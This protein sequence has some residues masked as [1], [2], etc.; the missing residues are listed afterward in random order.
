M[1]SLQK[2]RIFF[3]LFIFHTFFVQAQILTASEDIHILFSIAEH[4][5]EYIGQI[6]S[7]HRT[8]V[9][10][11]FYKDGSVYYG[12]VVEGEPSG[13]G[14]MIAPT[15]GEISNCPES[16]CYVGRFKE[17]K[18]QG[19]GKV[20]DSAGTLIHQGIFANDA[21]IDVYM[22]TELVDYNSHFI[23]IKSEGNHYIGEI[24][25]NVPN[26]QGV[27][28]YSGKESIQGKFSNGSLKG[29]G[30]IMQA[31]GGWST[32]KE[33]D[34]NFIT[35]SSSANYEELRQ[36]RKSATMGAW[37]SLLT[38]FNR[39]MQNSLA[40]QQ[41]VKQERAAI[42]GVVISDDSSDSGSSSDGKRKSASKTKGS[43]TCMHCYG[44]GICNYCNGDGYNYAAGNFV[45]CTACSSNIGKCKWCKGTGKR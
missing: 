31:D 40:E 39:D 27:L 19:R 14:T 7:K 26:G 17:G 9:A 45:K 4:K 28:F 8:G 42:K 33:Q 36:Q 32:I 1:T 34:G 10:F 35:L 23:G 3:L 44:T 6:V 29:V 24:R 15:D 5:S 30:L 2:K 43:D 16:Y 12:D 22:N 38:D 20:Y 41:R 11:V 25:E 37:A 18:K 13:V 21:P